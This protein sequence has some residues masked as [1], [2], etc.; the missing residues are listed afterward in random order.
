VIGSQLHGFRL[1]IT[2]MGGNTVSALKGIPNR[3]VRGH[4][5]WAAAEGLLDH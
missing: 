2:K 1:K 5:L 3:L 4:V